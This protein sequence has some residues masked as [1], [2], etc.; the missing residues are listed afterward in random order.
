M[1]FKEAKYS[2]LRINRLNE[3]G[4]CLVLLVAFQNA[5]EQRIACA[6]E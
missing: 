4:V 6:L 1:L 2:A 3:I 5:D